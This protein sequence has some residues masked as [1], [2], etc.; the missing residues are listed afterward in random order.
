MEHARLADLIEKHMNANK[1]YM[2]QGNAILE[3]LENLYAKYIQ[4]N[5]EE[6]RNLIKIVSSNFLLDGEKLSYEYKKP[7]NLFAEGLFV[8]LSGG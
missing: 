1:S 6:K 5:D 2:E 8:K 3:L 7:F 4:Q